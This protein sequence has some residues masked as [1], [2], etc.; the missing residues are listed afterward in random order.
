MI[1]AHNASYSPHSV[2]DEFNYREGSLSTAVEA[3][4]YSASDMMKEVHIDDKCLFRHGDFTAAVLKKVIPHDRKDLVIDTNVGY[5]S[6]FS[7]FQF[8]PETL[9]ISYDI[10]PEVGIFQKD[11]KLVCIFQ[12]DSTKNVNFAR[13]ITKSCH[14]SRALCRLKSIHGEG[15]EG[16]CFVFPSAFDDE[17]R[18]VQMAVIQVSCKW[19]YECCRFSYTGQAI[20]LDKL[21][22]HIRSVIMQQQSVVVNVYGDTKYLYKFRDVLGLQYC[23]YHYNHQYPSARSIVL[24]VSDTFGNQFVLKYVDAKTKT[25]LQSLSEEIIHSSI[26]HYFKAFSFVKKYNSYLSALL[27]EALDPPLSA[28][29]AKNCLKNFIGSLHTTLYKLFIHLDLST[30]TCDLKTYVFVLMLVLAL[31]K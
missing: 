21:I 23:G 14:Y 4:L 9:S 30:V 28:M 2:C 6:L 31:T 13:S 7:N 25:I 26:L 27:Y 3:K 11:G 8:M 18:N 5:Q 10:R 22:S 20:A 24:N 12:E 1:S 16:V 17:V 15:Q 29:E 19:D